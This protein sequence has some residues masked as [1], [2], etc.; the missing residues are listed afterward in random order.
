MLDDIENGRIVVGEK[1]AKPF[2]HSKLQCS[3]GE[4]RYQNILGGGINREN[5]Q[6]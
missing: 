6:N 4:P 2:S 3:A 5:Y 1:Y